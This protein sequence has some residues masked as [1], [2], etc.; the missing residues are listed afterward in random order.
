MEVE[1]VIGA[2]KISGQPE[3]VRRGEAGNSGFLIWMIANFPIDL[4]VLIIGTIERF[5]GNQF[6]RIRSEVQRMLLVLLLG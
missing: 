3:G 6:S 1:G 2:E 4:A 5:E